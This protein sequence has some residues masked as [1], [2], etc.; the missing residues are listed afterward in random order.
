M[1]RI[2]IRKDLD[3]PNL[4]PLVRGTDPDPSL[5]LVKVVERSEILIQNFSCSGSVSQRYLDVT[6]PKR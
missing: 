1:F 2:Q 3:L 5:F 6:D 4:D